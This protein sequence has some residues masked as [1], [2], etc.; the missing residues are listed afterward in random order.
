M[1]RLGTL[2]FLDRVIKWLRRIARRRPHVGPDSGHTHQ[3]LKILL[4]LFH[5]ARCA[6]FALPEKCDTSLK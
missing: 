6:Q 2:V 1:S 5:I 3:I 4:L